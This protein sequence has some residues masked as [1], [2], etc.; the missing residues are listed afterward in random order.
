MSYNK[1]GHVL[2]TKTKTE[3]LQGRIRVSKQCEYRIKSDKRKKMKIFQEVELH[4]LLKFGLPNNVPNMSS[5]TQD[6]SA[7]PQP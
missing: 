5:I 6:L 2:L 3:W 7:N 4:V 1:I